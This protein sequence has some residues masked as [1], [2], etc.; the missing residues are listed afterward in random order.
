MIQP[1]QY[2]RELADRLAAA[3]A[4]GDPQL[5]YDTTAEIVQAGLRCAV[6]VIAALMPIHH[7]D[8]EAPTQSG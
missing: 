1:T 3:A 8:T 7:R 6:G 2:D 5:Y 4:D